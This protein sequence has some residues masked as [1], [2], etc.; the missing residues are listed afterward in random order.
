M[1]NEHAQYFS[2]WKTRDEHRDDDAMQFHGTVVLSRYDEPATVAAIGQY[3]DTATWLHN[4]RCVVL[5]FGIPKS[6]D[7][8]F[9]S[10]ASGRLTHKLTVG[11]VVE[12]LARY[13]VRELTKKVVKKIDG[14]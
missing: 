1:T 14:R 12:G 2:V 11:R 5:P 4:R 8:R 3:Q 13:A 9:A 7:Y 10:L 6:V